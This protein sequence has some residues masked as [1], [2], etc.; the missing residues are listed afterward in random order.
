VN[1][2]ESIKELASA[3]NKAQ[4]EMTGAKKSA[5]NPFFKSNYSKLSEVIEV[6]REPLSNNGLSIAQLP[7]S[8]D[9]KCGVETILMHTS[10][11]WI[12]QKLLVASP[13]QDP[14]GYGS[15]ITYCR[16][17]SWQ[18]VLGIPSEDDDGHAAS[19]KDPVKS[20][21]SREPVEEVGKCACGN[22][23]NGDYARCW[24]CNQKGG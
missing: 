1:K 21:S 11:E 5:Y 7:L 9:N 8:E 12:S 17:Y 3:L 15:C 22:Q 6:S 19:H 13:K 18:S 23:I 4:S 2:S 16:R 24:P 20:T 10:G 14:Q